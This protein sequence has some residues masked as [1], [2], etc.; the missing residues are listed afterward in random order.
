MASLEHFNKAGRDCYRLRVQINRKRCHVSLTGLDQAAASIAKEQIEHLVAQ[1]ALDRPPSEKA[2]RWLETL[3]DS[4]H[5]RLSTLG[6]VEARKRIELPRTILAFMRHYISS[7]SDWKKSTNHKQ[8]VNHLEA[9]LKRDIPLSALTEGDAEQ[10]HAWM[11][12]TRKGPGLSPNTAGQHVKRCRQMVTAAMKHRLVQQN[13]FESVKIDLRSDVSKDHEV[14]A[15][16]ALAI[17]EA[18]PDQEWRT[19]FALVRYGG[20]RCPSEVLKLK[21]SDIAWDRDR[22]KVTSPKTSRYGKKERIV[23]LFPELRTELESLL[24]LSEAR[25]GG[26]NAQYVIRRYRDGDQNIRTTFAKICDRAGVASFSKPFMNCR[27]SRRNELER[28]GVRSAALNAW[29]GH[30]QAVAERHYEKVTEDDYAEVTNQMP[31]DVGQT[32]GQSGGT[33]EASVRITDAEKPIK[34][35]L[36]VLSEGSRSGMEY[37]PEDSNL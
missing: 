29:F 31:S 15:Q 16:E 5:D 17:L 21:W 23:P 27:S 30:S 10:W 4:I 33:L 28:Q 2:S 32:V 3:P 37:T 14:S 35:P 26:R 18:C 1:A 34:K 20:L 6:L 7:R 12:D 8:S 13:A 9:F 11:M 24:E 36:L 22:F 19:L 25:S